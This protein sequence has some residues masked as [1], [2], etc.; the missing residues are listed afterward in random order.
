MTW[1]NACR[2][3]KM[4]ILF[5]LRI[6]KKGFDLQGVL[7]PAEQPYVDVSICSYRDG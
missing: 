7:E 2:F 4:K 3:Y 1:E 5:N 6:M